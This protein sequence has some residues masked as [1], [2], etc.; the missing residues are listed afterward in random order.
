MRKA[1]WIGFGLTA[2]ALGGM[3]LLFPEE[4]AAT[5]R[6]GKD[7]LPQPLSVAEAPAAAPES[8]WATWRSA[9]QGLQ[10]KHPPEWT[11]TPAPRSP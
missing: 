9:R 5:R 11:V 4:G 1:G 3:W 6:T 10:M 7:A 2:F 8:A